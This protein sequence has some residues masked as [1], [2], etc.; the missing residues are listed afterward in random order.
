MHL[1][2]IHE[3]GETPLP[4][5][6]TTAV[7]ID[8]GT[9]H[10]V[11]AV[12]TDQHPEVICDEAGE[13]IIPSVVAYQK[14]G[15]LVGKRAKALFAE[16]AEDVIASAKRMM[17]RSA[18]DLQLTDDLT[19]YE[20]DTS[21]AGMVK[22]VLSDDRR[23][24]SVEVSSEILKHLRQMAEISL[25]RGVKKA[26]ITVP[27]YFD[28]AARSATRDAAR[29][30][31]LE[32]LRLINEPTAAALAYGLEKGAE[33]IYAIYDLGGG[34]F[35][36]S[37]LRLQKGVFQVLATA[38]STMLGG[39]D[40]DQ[41]IAE[42]VLEQCNIDEL[43]HAESAQLLSLSRD[44]KE[45]LSAANDAAIEWS[46]KKISI[47][48]EVFA[49]LIKHYLDSTI[50]ISSRAMLDASLDVSE[51]KGV[52]LVG[53]STRIPA[54]QL[55]VAACFGK[56][57]LCDIDPD[58]VVALGAAIQAEGLTKGSDN[59]LLDV[60]PLSLG[61]ETM[62]GIVE[63]LIYRNSPIP[64]SVSQEFTT[65]ADNQTG[66]VIH[67]LQ[68]EREM[69]NQCRSLAK[70]ELKGIPPLPAG[71][72][73]VKV[74]F[75]VDADG[76]LSVTASEMHTGETQHVEVQPSY[77]L[78]IEEVEAMLRASMENAQ[79]DILQ[80]LLI[81]V[82]VEASRLINE[83]KSSLKKDGKLLNEEE[84]A[85]IDWQIEVLRAAMDSDVREK[86]EYETMQ[87]NEGIQSFAEKRMNAAIAASLAG[88]HVE[89]VEG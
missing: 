29:I 4:H 35:D 42:Y 36:F 51:V 47:T 63:K 44:A 56:A 8:L 72:A 77:G 2:Q 88:K 40:F 86:I 75:T 16:G 7:G 13:S 28:D 39:D 30:A 12:A 54:V 87:L 80:R 26:V 49:G 66:M 84:K 62:G 45:K 69:V 31:G 76:L 74:S 59:L 83:V 52:V 37:L 57:P 71:V 21:S 34:T 48:R 89:E 23:I 85:R 43:D 50:L 78:S 55:A 20:L 9:T 19:P 1:M 6:D 68:G 61:L 58:K 22:I 24:S 27:A 60:T 81:E 53:G 65:Y 82:R 67:V 11:I 32:V 15:L 3:P 33:G 10:S 5:A 38:G 70:F 18:H 14:N 17:G 41:A 25:G 79:D 64:T 73:R 46:G